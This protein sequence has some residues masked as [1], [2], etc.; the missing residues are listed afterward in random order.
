MYL[1]TDVNFDL[2]HSTILHSIVPRKSSEN[3][4]KYSKMLECIIS[5]QNGIN[6]IDLW[7]NEI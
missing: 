1:S 7:S 6:K 2:I 3:L 4:S 5:E